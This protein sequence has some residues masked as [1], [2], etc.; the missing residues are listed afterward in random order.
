MKVLGW[1]FSFLVAILGSALVLSQIKYTDHSPEMKPIGQKLLSRMKDW[2]I[3]SDGN[4]SDIKLGARI[5]GVLNGVG[6]TGVRVDQSI[7]TVMSA[8]NRRYSFTGHCWIPGGELAR[9]DLTLHEKE[10]AE[11]GMVIDH[12]LC[13]FVEGRESWCYTQSLVSLPSR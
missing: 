2:R 4:V 11:F 8:G 12:S 1:V 10:P 6:C 13:Y 3:G 9:I 7:T 5:A